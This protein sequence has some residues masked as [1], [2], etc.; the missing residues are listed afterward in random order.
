MVF[1]LIVWLLLCTRV[2][3]AYQTHYFY[4]EPLDCKVFEELFITLT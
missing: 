3:L 4:F 1:G 2:F